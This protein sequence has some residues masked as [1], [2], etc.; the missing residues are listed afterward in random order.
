MRTRLSTFLI[1]MNAA[2]I[3]IVLSTSRSRV[4]AQRPADPAPLIR[5][6]SLEIVDDAGRVRA[7]LT[8][9]SPAVVD[10]KQYPETVLLRLIDPEAGP[11]VKLTAAANGSAL[12]LSD[13]A[14]GGVQV[15]GR[16]TG[17]FVK[18]VSKDGKEVTV[19][20]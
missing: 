3:A 5:T 11:V 4:E 18:V 2:L 14:D 10:G 1:A 7:L 12:T 17:S 15:F 9:Q 16:D 20:P 8:V 13:D 6:R 19:K